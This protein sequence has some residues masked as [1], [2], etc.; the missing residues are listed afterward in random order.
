MKTIREPEREIPVVDEVDLAV[1][2]GS[3]TGVFAAVRAARLGL[4]V[5][6]VE[7]HNCF[8]GVATAGNVNIW[9]SL[10]DTIGER[11]IIGGLTQELL[12]RLSARDAVL[13]SSNPSSAFRLNTEELKIELDELVVEHGIVPYLHTFYA[14]PLIEDGK[15]AA[16][17]IQNKNGRGA[18]RSQQFIDAT[19][20]ADLALDLQ[21]PYFEP[22]TLQPPT[23]CAKIMGLNSLGDFNWQQAVCEHGAEFGLDPDW[24]WGGPI[25]GMTDIHLRADTHVFGCDTSDGSQ[26]SSAEIEGRRQ[27]RAILDLIRK[28]GPSDANIALVDLAAVIG[29]RETKRIIAAHRLTGDDVLNGRR[30]EDA[31][32]NGSYRVDIHHADGPGITFRYLDGTETVIPE[33]GARP[34]RKRWRDPL[35]VDPT[36]YQIPWSCQLQNH[37]PNLALSGRML[38]ADKVAFSAARVMVNMNQTGE[39]AGVACALAASECIPI[40]N[41]DPAK[42]RKALAKG[43]SIII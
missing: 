34:L 12:D 37:I 10:H 38:D 33:R 8:G 11:R 31:I 25:P 2:G 30:F 3:C 16:I 35:D 18:I 43:G 13:T 9:H 29:A 28:Y 26:L 24:G 41:V 20:D 1:V 4:S 7:K 22:E 27:V 32:A 42:I 39:A 23:T 21:L 14:G 5:A 6:I 17:V 36:F 15:L 19:G 40:Q